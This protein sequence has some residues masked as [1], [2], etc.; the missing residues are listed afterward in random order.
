MEVCPTGAI[1]RDA[2]LEIV[3]IDG[4][5]CITCAMCAL[6]C[7]FDVIR[8]Y[9]SPLI[10]LDKDVALKCDHCIDRQ[11]EGLEPACVEVCKVNA[12]LFG[13]VNELIRSASG[14][15]AQEVSLAAAAVRPEMQRLPAMVE[16]WRAWGEDVRKVNER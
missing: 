13:E 8:Y 14:R 6:V 16:A 1:A 4:K 5:K 15:L 2:D 12:L 3:V 10:H 9:H 7:P 11:R